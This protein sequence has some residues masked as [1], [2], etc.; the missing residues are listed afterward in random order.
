MTTD[1]KSMT[2]KQL[3]KLGRDVEKQLDRLK[4]QDMKAAR[5]AAVKAAAAHGFKL[6]ELVGGSGA[7]AKP[8][9]AKAKSAGVAKYAN[10]DDKSQTWTGKGRQPQWFKDAIA[11]GKS[12]DTMEI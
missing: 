6:D 11:A 8:R 7:A 5:D 12:P 2:R 4:K 1:L 9:K 3:E 10:P